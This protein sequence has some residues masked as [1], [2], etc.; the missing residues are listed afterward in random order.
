MLNVDSTASKCG[1]QIDLRVIEQVVI[2]ALEPRVRLLLNL[3]NNI[4]GHHAR[5][6]VTLATEFNLV[7]ITHTF[8]D[9][10]VQHLALHDGLLTVAFLATVF[11]TDD[12]ALTVAVRTDSLES[13]DHG[14]HLA[15]HCLHTAT[16]ATRALLDSTLL[17]SA[18]IASGTDDG[19]LQSQFRHLAAVNV[20]EV[21][22]VNVVN[23]AGLFGASIA[24]ATAEHPTERTAATEELREQ[25][26]GVHA[27]G[28]AAALQTL[29]T[30][31]V[32][33]LALLGIGQNLVRGRQ[34]LELLCRL[35]VIGVLV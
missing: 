28:A 6:L 26:L 16:I 5:H 22:L 30:I 33:N 19:F 4:T 2:L 20:F 21:D 17:A 15:H 8:V 31:L 12:L 14:T 27:T 13:L 34:F 10:D 3:K 11:V 18:A 23:S 24:H 32:V 35:R 9:V 29:L 1:Q 7:A 25:I